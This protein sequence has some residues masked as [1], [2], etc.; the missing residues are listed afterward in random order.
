MSTWFQCKK[1]YSPLYTVQVLIKVQNNVVF[2]LQSQKLR[3][4]Q[5]QYN[6]NSP[7]NEYK[8]VSV[9]LHLAQK[10][11]LCIGHLIIRKKNTT[12]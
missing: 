5:F 2:H 10:I 12:Q 11:K 9:T 7:H 6:K 3:N 8:T 1:K 4:V